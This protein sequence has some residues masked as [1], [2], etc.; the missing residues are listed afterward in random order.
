[1]RGAKTVEIMS[2]YNNY[3]PETQEKREEL[4]RKI[5]K[6]GYH[7][8][9]NGKYMFVIGGDGTFLK[10]VHH[11]AS[12]DPIFIGINAGNLGFFSEFKFYEI[13][14]IFELIKKENF[15]IQE[16]PI[17]QVKVKD[18]EG[19]KVFK[20]IN[21]IVVER[22]S[23]RVIHTGIH[24]N[25]QMFSN[26]SGDGIVVSTSIGSTGYGTNIGGMISLDCDDVLQLNTVGGVNSQVYSS[27]SKPIMLK[28][29]NKIT[30]YPSVKKQRPYR[31]ATDGYDLKLYDVKYI[32][33]KK[34]DKKVRILRS[35][36][37]NQLQIIKQ[38]IINN[39]S[40]ID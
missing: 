30:I 8:G 38:K 37:Y 6:N 34:T 3:L 31:I 28:D 19:T 18:A 12:D 25:D 4:T 16:I 7:T 17:Y 20:F 23:S 29:T 2:I 14:Q 32:E 35:K 40:F 33:I 11:N 10:A 15:W 26:F 36:R 9:K 5:K 27:L 13:D 1:V 39:D 21:D 22:K 24:I